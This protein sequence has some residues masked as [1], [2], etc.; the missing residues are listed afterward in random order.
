MENIVSRFKIMKPT[1]LKECSP[2]KL[3]HDCKIC[4]FLL[5]KPN[6]VLIDEVRDKNEIIPQLLPTTDHE[7][8]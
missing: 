6:F 5:P 1:I 4:S 7:H 8:F 3:A 2:Y